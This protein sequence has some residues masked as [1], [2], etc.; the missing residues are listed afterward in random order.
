M[1]A[2][3]LLRVVLAVAAAYALGSIPTA[4]LAGQRAG[5]DIRDVGDGNMGARNVA[6]SLGARPAIIVALV[7]VFKGAVAVLIARALGVSEDWVHVAAWAAV[8]GHDFPVFAGFQGGQ[9]LAPR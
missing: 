6:R 3:E 8:L 7:D 1:I 9:G 2:W 5:I 4:V